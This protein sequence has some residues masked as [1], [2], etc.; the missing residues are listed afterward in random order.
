VRLVKIALLVAGLLLQ[1]PSPQP[2][3]RIPSNVAW[4]DDTVA[5]ASSG[6]PVRGLVIARRCEHCH[7]AEGFSAVSSIPNLAGLD[8]L[9]LWKQLNDFRSGKRQSAA[10]KPVAAGLAIGDYAD[11]AAYYAIL[12][13]YADPQDARAF[14]QPLPLSAHTAVAE[15]L[16]SAGDGARGI[17][18]CQVCHGP[19][20]VKMGA[21]SLATQNSSYIRE[22][23]E[24]FAR[25]GRAND[26]NM[27][28]RS[29]AAQLREDEIRAIADYY[30]AGLAN[31]PV[32]ASAT[33]R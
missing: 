28:M 17:P 32:G 15:R 26:I 25:G 30:G 21:P 1:F 22:E 24:K 12:P 31:S 9:T 7:G 5:T 6:D 13:A 33:H 4:T 3:V 2:P 10:M 27:P 19:I 16:I 8:R 20:A 29:I 23:L 11:L 18:P 14:P